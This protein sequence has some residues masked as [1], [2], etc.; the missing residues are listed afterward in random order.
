MMFQGLEIKPDNVFKITHIEAD[1]KDQ[2]KVTWKQPNG[3]GFIS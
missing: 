2:D 3:I 1:P